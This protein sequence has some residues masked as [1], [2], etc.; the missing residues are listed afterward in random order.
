MSQ[1][2][3]FGRYNLVR[4]VAQGGMAE[5]FLAKFQGIGGFEK[6]IIIKRILPRFSENQEFIKM[7]IHEAKIAVQ[8][9]HQNIV[10]IYDLGKVRN[11]Y[12]ISMEYIRGKDL[13]TVLNR[14]KAQGLQMPQEL[15]VFITREIC[16]GLDYAH[17][18]TDQHGEPLNL[19]HRDISP[20]N[21]LLSLEGEVKIIDFGIAKATSQAT[22]TQA[23]VFKGKFAYMAPEQAAGIPVDR[24]SDIFA[25]GLIL[26]EMLTC[27][28]LLEAETDIATLERAKKIDSFVPP[29]ANYD[30]PEQIELIIRK[31]L[32]QERDTRYQA[33]GEAARDLTIY[34][35]LNYPGFSETDLAD[36]LRSLFNLDRRR[37][38]GS[39]DIVTHGHG[40]RSLTGSDFFRAFARS[41]ADST[42]PSVKLRNEAA[43]HV[44]ARAGSSPGVQLPGAAIAATGGPGASG[45]APPG[46]RRPKEGR[47]PGDSDYWSLESEIEV[48]ALA[49]GEGKKAGTGWVSQVAEDF[50]PAD[51]GTLH[52][53]VKGGLADPANGAG[54]TS[55]LS[56]DPQPVEETAEDT[57]DAS[58]SLEPVSD[59]EVDPKAEGAKDY[60]AVPITPPK[61]GNTIGSWVIV[62][63]T[64][65]V[66]FLL[67]VAVVFPNKMVEIRESLGLIRK[68]TVALTYEPS[69]ALISVNGQ[70]AARLPNPAQLHLTIGQ[71]HSVRISQQGFADEQLSIDLVAASRVDPIKVSLNPLAPVGNGVLTLTG[72]L[73]GAVLY[74]NDRPMLEDQLKALPTGEP[75]NIRVIKQHYETFEQEVI[76]DSTPLELEVEM[77][78]APVPLTV[79]ADDIQGAV[80]TVNT[81]TVGN[82][83]PFVGSFIPGK[84]YQV[85]VKKKGYES[86]KIHWAP[87]VGTPFLWNVSLERIVTRKP[88]MARKPSTVPEDGPTTQQASNTNQP[89]GHNEGKGSSTQAAHQ[90]A[91]RQTASKPTP[92][93]SPI[94]GSGVKTSAGTSNDT[95]PLS[96]TQTAGTMRITIIATPWAEVYVDD[97]Y[98]GRTPVRNIVVHEGPHKIRLVNSD[99]EIDYTT[100]KDIKLDPSGGN[101]LTYN[102]DLG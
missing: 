4:K 83:C 48:F 46:G 100:E 96:E 49:E 30:I 97:R 70:P 45:K 90:Q 12:F 71:R 91:A 92:D 41:A 93:K 56:L 36:F 39:G 98:V 67:V 23:G 101:Q 73:P 81:E 60:S 47:K 13:R 5:I 19:V 32:R 35:N 40:E 68:A 14:L 25:T 102:Y 21:I 57:L 76:L 75:L 54:I 16:K 2:K 53:L 8:L 80:V 64:A 38:G 77:A 79:E 88:E 29:F 95:K 72:L 85:E 89:K 26:W 37:G 87:L 20:P 74:V 82:C 55:E 44:A 22:D 18:I 66:I 69:D 1:V 28:K 50:V 51:D 11:T 59:D 94:P 43:E 62:G 6:K 27:N 33:A 99:L 86:A 10:Q 24:R 17:N 31:T 3:T 58:L 65:A 63:L 84:P 9:H 15:A 7:L 78:P 34:L 52:P 61:T 42:D